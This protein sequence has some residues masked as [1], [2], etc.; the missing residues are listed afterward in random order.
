[1]ARIETCS[2]K[3]K[4]VTDK[5]SEFEFDEVVTTAPLGWLK[6]NK[7]TFIPPLPKRLSQAIDAIGYGSLEKALSFSFCVQ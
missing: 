5:G 2:D 1:V 7:Q 3:V 4:V 6:K